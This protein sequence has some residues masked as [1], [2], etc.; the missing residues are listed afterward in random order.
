MPSPVFRLVLTLVNCWFMNFAS[1]N[2]WDNGKI[3]FSHIIP[4]KILP[5]FAIK[6]RANNVWRQW[7]F[8]SKILWKYQPSWVAIHLPQFAKRLEAD[9]DRHEYKF[10]D[11]CILFCFQTNLG[12]YQSNSRD[13]SG[14]NHGS[15][16]R[17]LF[18]SCDN[19]Q[20]KPGNAD[21]CLCTEPTR[22]V[23][24][25]TFLSTQCAK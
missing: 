2:V 20:H 1:E 13:D 14:Y 19:L 11:N 16:V 18:S 3:A 8:I 4:W 22:K 5:T 7:S 12:I 6:I 21:E 25:L 17:C 24:R 15:I 9:V 10:C 23:P